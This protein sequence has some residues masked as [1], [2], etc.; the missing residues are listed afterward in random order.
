M[1]FKWF[2]IIF[3]EKP[4]H[5][6]LS[7]DVEMDDEEDVDEN[8]DMLDSPW[9]LLGSKVDSHRVQLMKSSLF[10]CQ[11]VGTLKFFKIKQYLNILIT[12]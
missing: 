2:Y 1:K 11:P 8:V 12:R 10:H 5:Q 6:D 3:K 9:S 7:L 4:H